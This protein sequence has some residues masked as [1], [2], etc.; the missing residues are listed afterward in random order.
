MFVPGSVLVSSVLNCGIHMWVIR[1]HSS[2]R[3]E[4]KGQAGTTSVE[5]CDEKV[6]LKEWSM[7]PLHALV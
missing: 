6:A 3:I 2:K 4:S 7:A 5:V 1:R